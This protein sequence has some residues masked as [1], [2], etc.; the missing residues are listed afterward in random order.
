MA[1]N[2]EPYVCVEASTGNYFTS[3]TVPGGP[4]SANIQDAHVW[5]PGVYSR[6]A[7]TVDRERLLAS[8][9]PCPFTCLPVRVTRQVS[10]V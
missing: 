10:L 8:G 5:L 7:P 9:Q 1:A 4:T 2:M 3:T 6:Q